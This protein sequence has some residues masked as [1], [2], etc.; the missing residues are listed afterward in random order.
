EVETRA[1]GDPAAI[2]DLAARLGIKGRLGRDHV[3]AR[4]RADRPSRLG[5]VGD[6]RQDLGL[7]FDDPV[8]DETRRAVTEPDEPPGDARVRAFLRTARPL[9]LLVHRPLEG[10]LVD[11]EALAGE[12]V[13]GQIER[14][15]VGVVEPE[16]DLAG[17]R[18][19]LAASGR[20][21]LR[22]E[23]REPAVERLCE[24]L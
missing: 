24:A 6:E 17:E 3:D 8:A 13:L 19:R 16:G 1:R 12:D 2:A 20:L 4:A 10:V 21:D 5:T 7:P 15:S 23:E 22:G 18:R 14:E 11:D 9:A